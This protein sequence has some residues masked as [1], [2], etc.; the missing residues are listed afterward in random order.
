MRNLE[1]AE[2]GLG[3]LIWACRE[4][5]IWAVFS[6]DCAFK[7]RSLGSPAGSGGGG[8]ER[9]GVFGIFADVDL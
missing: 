4:G 7:R 1:G 6:G 8:S 9:G 3:R 2:N 5:R